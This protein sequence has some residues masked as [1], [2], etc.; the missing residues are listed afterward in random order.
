MEKFW[1]MLRVRP[2]NP[3]APLTVGMALTDLSSVPGPPEQLV[4]EHA[5]RQSR[6]IRIR[7]V[8]ARKVGSLNRE[9]DGD[10]IEL[11][12]G[13]SST[14]AA[15][16]CLHQLGHLMMGHETCLAH[17]NQ[18]TGDDHLQEIDASMF[19]DLVL[20][21]YRQVKRATGSQHPKRG[22]VNAAYVLGTLDDRWPENASA[23]R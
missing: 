1:K 19:A 14:L 6:Q 21:R 4:A 3:V 7:Y 16:K 5:A 10:V 15:D 22:T 17:L 13:A 9:Q 2:T 12:I 11:P 8:S 18:P 20:A 23:V